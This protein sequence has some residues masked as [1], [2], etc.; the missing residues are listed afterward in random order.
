[1]KALL[2]F[3]ES[4]GASLKSWVVSR[5]RYAF[6][7]YNRGS[8]AQFGKRMTLSIDDE[9]SSFEGVDSS[10]S[11][12][13]SLVGDNMIAA[14]GRAFGPRMMEVIKAKH[15]GLS[16]WETAEQLG[17]EMREVNR[18]LMTFQDWFNETF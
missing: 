5:L 17:L 11:P 18:T 7:E 9:L 2:N 4:K 12:Y 13:E 1:M 10:D 3:D 15:D 16:H 6:I 8:K 14:F